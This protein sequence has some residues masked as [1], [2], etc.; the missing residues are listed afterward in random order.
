[1]ESAQLSPGPGELLRPC[2]PKQLAPGS[3]QGAG[4]AGVRPGAPEPLVGGAIARGRGVRVC[5]GCGALVDRYDQAALRLMDSWWHRLCWLEGSQERE[6][7]LRSQREHV[8][9]HSA[10]AGYLLAQERWGGLP[11]VLAV[12]NLVATSREVGADNDSYR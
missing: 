2:P 5:G 4:R 9:R 7:A 11:A 6:E 10:L 3:R 1:M 12:G 8:G